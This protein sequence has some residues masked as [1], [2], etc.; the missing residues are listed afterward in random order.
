MHE[1][2]S[3]ILSGES[4]PSTP[5][6]RK[7]RKSEGGGLGGLAKI[8]IKR[9]EARV[10][11]QRLEDRLRGIV[12]RT[13]IVF[14]RRR[15][16]VAVINVSSRGAMIEAE[17]EPRIGE[18]MDILFADQ[19]RT[20]CVVRW[21]REGRI[22]V[23]F[24][25]ETILW[26]S[27]PARAPVFQAEN[28]QDEPALHAVADREPRQKLLR[29]GTL[30][31]SGISIQVRLRNISGGGARVESGRELCPGF[32]SRP[33]SRPSSSPIRPGRRASSGCRSPI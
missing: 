22:G 32:S 13:T 10:T 28:P 29:S 33:I 19:N 9:E 20:N 18:K 4:R 12:E 14:R 16:E 2:R 3:T 15:H 27:D 25:N 1:L 24:V 7:A 30:Y 17:V 23:E 11:N 6:A 26:T 21:V 31:W 8:A 5:V